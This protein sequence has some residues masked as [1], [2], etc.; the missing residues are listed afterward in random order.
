M[1]YFELFGLDITFDIDNHQLSGLYQALQKSV[2]PDRYAHASDQEQ[3]IA[4]QKSS[5]INDAY[6]TLKTPLKRAE[7]ILT[8]R[9]TDMPNAQASFSDNSFLMRQMELHELL[10]DIDDADD[11]ET[12]IAEATQMLDEE[13]DE[14]FTT[15]QLLLAE[16]TS[17]ANQFASENLRKLKFY[18]KLQG[19]LERI[20]ERLLDD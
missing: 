1:N 2:H 18:Q 12:A 17:V 5:M 9:N 3:R 8:L 10:S 14:L 16:N 6:Q 19:D 4:V 11:V 20:E 7:Y 13:F 15:L